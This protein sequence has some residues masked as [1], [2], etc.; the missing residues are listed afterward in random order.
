[1]FK[2]I[3]IWILYL[4]IVLF[5]VFTIFFGVLVR[6]EL[7]GT[8]KLGIISKY[9]LIISEIPLNLRNIYNQIRDDG[10]SMLADNRQSTKPNFKR[11]KNNDRYELMVLSRFDGDLNKASVEII[12]LNDFSVI[13]K[14]NPDIKLINKKALKNNKKE[15]FRIKTEATPNRFILYHPLIDEEGNLVSHSEE[16]PIFKMDICN[17]INWVNSKERFHHSNE[18]DHQNNYWAPAYM[19]PYSKTMQIYRN[20][21]GLLDD[22]ITKI[23]KNGKILYQKSIFD[24]LI[25]GKVVRYNDLY[26]NGDPIHL[27]DIQP[28]I[29]DTKYW[30]KGDLFLSLRNLNTIILYRPSNNEV[31]KVIT[32]PFVMQHDVDIISDNE[33]SIFNN[34]LVFTKEGPVAENIDILIYNF[35]TNKFYKKFSQTILDNDII[36]GSGG[37]SDFLDDGSLLI[38]EQASGRLLLF[39]N[40]GEL[41]WEYVNKNKNDTIYQTTWSRIIKDKSIIKNLKESI[42]NKDCK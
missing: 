31:L 30:K 28:V 9:A 6:Q 34:N 37:L 33:I 39:D 3:E 21:K 25:E 10:Y 1:M 40:Q 2:K 24:I 22:A 26:I 7:V 8:K 23:S 14:Y 36:T 41:E 38:E 11:F 27:N 29:K 15:F 35:D 20:R 42:K 19:Q 4:V 16:G 32:G 5:V 18:V 13:H 17:N 12:N